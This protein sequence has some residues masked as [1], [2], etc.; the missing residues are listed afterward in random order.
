MTMPHLGILVTLFGLGYPD[1][2]PLEG[3][4]AGRFVRGHK[5]PQG[6]TFEGP[7]R[8]GDQPAIRQDDD[9]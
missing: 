1:A 3:D 8:G 9:S 6:L 2:H 7:T 4:L 5:N